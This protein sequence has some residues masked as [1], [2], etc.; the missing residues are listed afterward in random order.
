MPKS[1]RGFSLIELLV[2]M[3]LLAVLATISFRATNA[4]DQAYL[5]VMESDLKNL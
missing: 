1:E 5:A 2:A 3:V 4:R